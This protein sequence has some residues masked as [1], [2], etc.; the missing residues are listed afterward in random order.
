MTRSRWAFVPS[1]LPAHRGEHHT[2]VLG[3]VVDAAMTGGEARVIW[4]K[5]LRWPALI[6]AVVVLG[7]LALR[8]AAKPRAA[9]LAGTLNRVAALTEIHRQANEILD[10]GPRAF[11]ARLASLDGSPIVVNQWASWCGPCRYEFPFFQRLARKYGTRVAFLGVDSQDNRADARRFLRELPVPYPH[12]YDRD[13]S[14]ARVFRGG[15]AWPTTA[16]YDAAGTL[17]LTHPGA[18]ATQ[19]KLEADILSYALHG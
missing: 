6:L 16:F 11:R 9:H 13:A 2:F 14:I 3:F 12:Y 19:A 15:Q 4:L 18:Y 17:A 5:R 10:G 7:F 1:G 8:P